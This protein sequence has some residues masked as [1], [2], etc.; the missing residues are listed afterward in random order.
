ML[1]FNAQ[2]IPPN[3]EQS[4]NIFIMWKIDQITY[5]QFVPLEKIKECQIYFFQTLWDS[6]LNNSLDKSVSLLRIISEHPLQLLLLNTAIINNINMYDSDKFIKPL[7]IKAK[8]KSQLAHMLC[9]NIPNHISLNN[10]KK[11]WRIN[12]LNHISENNNNFELLI[13]K[14]KDII[15]NK[16]MEKRKNQQIYFYLEDL[17]ITS[18]MLDIF[19]D[20]HLLAIQES[21]LQIMAI[22]IEKSDIIKPIKLVLNNKKL[23]F[24]KVKYN[25]SNSLTT[26]DS[27]DPLTHLIL[28]ISLKFNTMKIHNEL[29]LFQEK[30]NNNIKTVNLKFLDTKFNYTMGNLI[31]PEIIYN[32][33]RELF[34]SLETYCNI[35]I[36]NQKSSLSMN[37]T[38]YKK[39][40]HLFLLTNIMNNIINTT[41]KITNINIDKKDIINH[42]FKM[43]NF[44]PL[45]FNS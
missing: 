11:D 35:K 31:F 41:N 24:D 36:I 45:L 34:D 40:V 22:D 39:S 33:N 9:N 18:N 7:N 4:R 1:I 38:Q 37:E 19:L 17:D 3:T 14:T 25:K 26:F 27:I 2:K 43:F 15:S 28:W 20:K 6:I 5:S 13:K 30:S 10:K 29:M 23:L 42:A 8:P 12:H 21:N 32:K 16:L 44:L